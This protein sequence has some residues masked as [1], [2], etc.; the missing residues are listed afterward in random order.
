MDS[1]E[2]LPDKIVSLDQVRINRGIEKICKCDKRTFVIDPANRRINCNS[3]GAVVDP[4]DAMYELA[5][6]GE[7]M[8][9][10]VERL[11]EQ[12]KQIANYKPWL[13]VIK[14]LEKQ[15]RGRK[16]IPNCPRCHEPFYL[17][18]IVHWTGKP[19]ADARIKKYKTTNSD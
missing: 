19:Y 16:M 13:K 8:K 14:N 1:F 10:S 2:E 17:E 5:A 9:E 18:E 3:C 6:K 12:R 4:Y 15:Y 7:R 11:L